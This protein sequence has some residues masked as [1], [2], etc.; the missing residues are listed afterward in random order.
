[1]FNLLVTALT[2]TFTTDMANAPDAP[3]GYYL[4]PP[5]APRQNPGPTTATTA[6]HATSVAGTFLLKVGKVS[7]Q[8][9]L[10]L[11]FFKIFVVTKPR[12]DAF[13]GEPE[14]SK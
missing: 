8:S 9:Q 4:S 5:I 6:A 10:F 11:Y 14:R 3:H 1:M 2:A 7:I 13:A 12:T